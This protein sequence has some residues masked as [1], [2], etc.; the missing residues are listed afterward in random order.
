MYS[1]SNAFPFEIV[2]FILSLL[3]SVIIIYW[4]LHFISDN[5][6]TKLY[7]LSLFLGFIHYFVADHGIST[8]FKILGS[9]A[10]FTFDETFLR[11]MAVIFFLIT[12]IL[13]F[14]L[15]WRSNIRRLK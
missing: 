6:R 2:Y 5:S 8:L 9:S 1:Y 7:F 10:M 4:R 3:F 13:T 12:L 14:N 15:F 11:N